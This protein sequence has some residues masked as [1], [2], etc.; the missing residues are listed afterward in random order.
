[1]G[2]RVR[3][4]IINLLL[5]KRMSRQKK[6]CFK[7]YL[8]LSLGCSKPDENKR[9]IESH[10]QVYSDSLCRVSYQG[11]Q[12]EVLDINNLS[13]QR[14]WLVYNSL[15]LL[16]VNP[17]TM[18]NNQYIVIE[19]KDKTEE[20]MLYIVFSSEFAMFCTVYN[21]ST[22]IES[23]WQPTHQHYST[24]KIQALCIIINLL[25]WKR[26]IRQGKLHCISCPLLSFRY[27]VTDENRRLIIS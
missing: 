1:M 23:V 6:L 20:I 8:L 17:C 4:V 22:Q 14:E 11:R 19:T 26:T 16:S 7:P 18:H 13:I 25:L 15:A 12:Y 21:I 5:S 2:I 9:S 24:M 3:C 27:P 10:C